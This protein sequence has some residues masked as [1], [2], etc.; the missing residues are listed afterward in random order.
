MAQT[1]VPFG[2]VPSVRDWMGVEAPVGQP[3]NACAK[4][5]VQ[6]FKLKRREGSGKRLWGWA[7]QRFGSAQAFFSRAFVWNYC[8]VLFLEAENAKNITPD[9]LSAQDQANIY[10]ICD[11]LLLAWIDYL[12]PEV[13]IGVGNF[14]QQRFEA[15]LANHPAPPRIGK[16]LHPSPASP[17]ANHGWDTTIEAQL[18]ELGLGDWFKP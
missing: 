3:A 16:I 10:A 14:A 11:P 6:G 7:E 2:D 15:V 8:P 13:V 4:K 9:K 1:G 17:L 5:P 12:Q 18:T